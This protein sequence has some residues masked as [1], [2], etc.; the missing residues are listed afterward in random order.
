MRTLIRSALVADAVLGTHG[1]TVDTI[2]SGD[3]DSIK[4]RPFINLK[5]GDDNP[6]LGPISRRNLVV[7]VH[8][9]PDDYTRVDAI[10]TRVRQ[11]LEGVCGFTET[12]YVTQIHWRTSS[13][14]L[15]DT[16]RGTILRTATYEI[17]G[18]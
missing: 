1:L 3:A 13:S 14:D 11:V 2:V 18:R 8:D 12:G 16:D 6:G 10:L 9:E 17:V 5:F 7:W 4:A 15:A